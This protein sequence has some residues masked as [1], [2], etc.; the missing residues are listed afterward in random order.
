MWRLLR[1]GTGI[2]PCIAAQ[3]RQLKG[4]ERGL[5]DKAERLRKRKLSQQRAELKLCC[6]PLRD[7][8]SFRFP[9]IDTIP[10]FDP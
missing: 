8:T 3:G 5:H 6:H 10:P 9:Q 7:Q 2:N 4:L 1:L